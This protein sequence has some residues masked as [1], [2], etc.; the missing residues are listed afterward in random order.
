M[1]SY[2]GRVFI[3]VRKE[4]ED[5]MEVD[6]VTVA[7]RRGYRGEPIAEQDY[8][9]V[10]D[11]LDILRGLCDGVYDIAARYHEEFHQDYWGEWDGNFWIEGERARWVGPAQ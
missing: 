6:S 10:A 8:S 5:F 7:P 9:A 1:N 3:R 4:G 11:G 2:V